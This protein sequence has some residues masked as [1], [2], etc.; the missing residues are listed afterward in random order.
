MMS[1]AMQA[2]RTTAHTSRKSEQAAQQAMLR[3]IDA[4]LARI[5]AGIAVQQKKMDDLLMKLSRR[6]A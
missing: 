6:A 2:K 1:A 3:E 4:A 5:D